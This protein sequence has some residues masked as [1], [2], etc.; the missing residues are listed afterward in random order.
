[1]RRK[2]TQVRFTRSHLK[3]GA[4]KCQD[5]NPNLRQLNFYAWD[6]RPI[7]PSHL[8]SGKSEVLLKGIMSSRLHLKRSQI[9]TKNPVLTVCIRISANS[10]YKTKTGHLDRF[11]WSTLLQNRS[12]WQKHSHVF[13]VDMLSSWLSG[14]SD[15]IQRNRELSTVKLFAHRQSS[16]QSQTTKLSG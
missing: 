2:Q 15:W 16:N 12:F 1:M 14:S 6:T 13:G 11:A 4:L 7:F 9:C 3:C 5:S 10:K 8:K